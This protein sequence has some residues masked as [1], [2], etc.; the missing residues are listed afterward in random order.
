MKIKLAALGLS[1]LVVAGMG[2]QTPSFA[3]DVWFSKYDRDHDGHWTWNEFNAAHRDWMRRH[4]DAER[5]SN[6][7]LRKQWDTWDA[8]HHGWVTVDHVRTYHHWD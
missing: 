1:L 3:D 2:I 8:D 4:R 5:I 7:E 6:A